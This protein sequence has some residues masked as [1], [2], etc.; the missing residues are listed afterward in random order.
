MRFLTGLCFGSALMLLSAVGY[1]RL[2]NEVIT[3][4]DV[5]VE[6]STTDAPEPL[7]QPM[8]VATKGDT[9]PPE[10]EGPVIEAPPVVQPEQ[11]VPV[12]EVAEI[13]PAR[14]EVSPRA[15]AP[16]PE[17]SEAALEEALTVAESA[18]AEAP[19]TRTLSVWQPFHSEM[20]AQ[21]FA[22][23]LSLQLGYPFTVIKVGPAEYHVVFSYEADSERDLL[24]EQLAN[25]TGVAPQ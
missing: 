14:T 11:P 2:S 4:T 5:A 6:T 23:R 17:S 19:D 7:D 1:D 18:T 22:K 12:D 20:S 15:D 13:A 25:L 9:A 24:S 3:P 16:K 10:F 21:G 8:S